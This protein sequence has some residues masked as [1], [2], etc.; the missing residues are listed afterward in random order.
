MNRT[1]KRIVKMTLL[2]YVIY[3]LILLLFMSVVIT[4]QLTLPTLWVHLSIFILP[5]FVAGACCLLTNKTNV[6]FAFKGPAVKDNLY[7][8]GI[9]LLVLVCCILFGIVVEAVRRKEPDLYGAA[10]LSNMPY[11]LT[12]SSFY[13]WVAEFPAVYAIFECMFVADN[14]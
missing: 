11:W 12:I 10:I 9:R 7:R 4:G 1:V 3:G 2:Q 13:I 6:C 8:L 5:V 14:A